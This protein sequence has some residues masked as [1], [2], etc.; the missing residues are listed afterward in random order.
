MSHHVHQKEKEEIVESYA[1]KEVV[2]QVPIEI[3]WLVFVFEL[4][5]FNWRQHKTFQSTTIYTK[6]AHNLEAS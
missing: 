4:P 5:F 3:G 6:F 1:P 2:F